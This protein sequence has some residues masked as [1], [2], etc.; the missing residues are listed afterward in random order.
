[1]LEAGWAGL[2]GCVK[3]RPPSGVDLR[4]VQPVASCYTESAIPAR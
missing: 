1:V 3:T 4:S 2:D